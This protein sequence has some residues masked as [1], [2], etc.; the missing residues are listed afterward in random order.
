MNFS[1]GVFSQGAEYERDHHRKNANRKGGGKAR[2]KLQRWQIEEVYVR[3]NRSCIVHPGSGEELSPDHHHDMAYKR[4]LIRAKARERNAPWLGY[5]EKQFN[6]RIS[7][8]FYFAS[9]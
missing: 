4:A 6:H 2:A 5:A 7:I 1:R 8:R 9:P 3:A